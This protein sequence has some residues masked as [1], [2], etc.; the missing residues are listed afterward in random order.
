MYLDGLKHANL[1]IMFK[2]HCAL[3]NRSVAS[4]TQR[5]DVRHLCLQVLDQS[6]IVTVFPIV[7][8][9]HEVLKG[10]CVGD[11][12]RPQTTPCRSL[13]N[14]SSNR[15]VDQVASPGNSGKLAA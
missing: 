11:S 2:N 14:I 12:T 7:G 1:T 13:I 3:L 5:F 8:T 4:G 15:C 9:K 6:H 10:D